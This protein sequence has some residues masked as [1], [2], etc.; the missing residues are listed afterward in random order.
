M[1]IPALTS[2]DTE[3]SEGDSVIL[4]C[5]AKGFPI[6]EV[7]WRREDKEAINAQSSGLSNKNKKG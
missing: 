4:R 6:P 1:F 2:S 5:A 3:V 7:Q